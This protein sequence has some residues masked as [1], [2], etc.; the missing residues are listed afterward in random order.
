LISF[1]EHTHQ[2]RNFFLPLQPS[3]FNQVRQGIARNPFSPSEPM[4]AQM[5]NS[6]RVASIAECSAH[7]R[8]VLVNGRTPRTD[9][10][11]AMCSLKIKNEYVRAPQT[12]LIYCDALCFAEDEK[13]TALV[14]KKDVRKVS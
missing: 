14:F 7:I 13:M 1:R 9:T 11:C 8:F 2:I 4:E 3:S 5:S 6:Q 10:A 12:E